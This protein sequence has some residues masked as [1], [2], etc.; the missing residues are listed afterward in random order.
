M[1]ALVKAFDASAVEQA[2]AGSPALLG[3]RD[4]RGRT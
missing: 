2:L 3:V 1:L 4:E